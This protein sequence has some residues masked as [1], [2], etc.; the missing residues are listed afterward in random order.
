ME[1][2]YNSE[3]PD[4]EYLKIFVFTPK[5]NVQNDGLNIYW[6]VENN[7]NWRRCFDCY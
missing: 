2:Q 5:K 7:P 6:S 4:V 3:C 1:T